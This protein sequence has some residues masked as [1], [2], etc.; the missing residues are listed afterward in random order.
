METSYGIQFSQFLIKRKRSYFPV[1]G[2]LVCFTLIHPFPRWGKLNTL[3]SFDSLMVLKMNEAE[4]NLI[5]SFLQRT[6]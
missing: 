1:L 3:S 2:A 4:P 5:F 6:C